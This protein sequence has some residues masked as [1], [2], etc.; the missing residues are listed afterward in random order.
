MKIRAIVAAMSVTVAALSSTAAETK[1]HY[2]Q[3]AEDWMEAMPIGN[4]RLS[5]MIYGGV[6][7]DRMALNEISMWSGQH[8][9]TSND[10]C[11]PPC[12]RHC[13]SVAPFATDK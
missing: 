8:D 7:K 11:L 5:G 10:L 12:S 9:P 6:K 3:P 4:G 2:N 1:L 13:I